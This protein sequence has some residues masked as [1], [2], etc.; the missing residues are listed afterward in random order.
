MYWLRRSVALT[1]RLLAA[2]WPAS[3]SLFRDCLLHS[4]PFQF[5]V[6]SGQIE[7]GRFPFAIRFERDVVALGFNRLLGEV[8][9]H[10]LQIAKPTRSDLLMLFGA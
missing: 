6:V 9:R 10:G 7:R 8:P 5:H 1:T 3:A 2:V 4:P